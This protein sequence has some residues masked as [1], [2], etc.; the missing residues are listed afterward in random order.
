MPP[1]PRIDYMLMHA[2]IHIRQPCKPPSENPG[3]RPDIIG[4]VSIR[5]NLCFCVC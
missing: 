5:G 3:Y 2:Y 1:D 4:N